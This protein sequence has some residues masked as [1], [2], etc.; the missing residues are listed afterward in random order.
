MKRKR[1]I[2]ISSLSLTL[3]RTSPPPV[4]LLKSTLTYHPIPHPF[5]KPD[6]LLQ[7]IF[8]DQA[9]YAAEA[10]KPFY[11]TKSQTGFSFTSAMEMYAENTLFYLFLLLVVCFNHPAP[12]TTSSSSPTKSIALGIC[13]LHC[14]MNFQRPRNFSD[15]V[16][17]TLISFNQIPD[18]Q[19]WQ[20]MSD[21]IIGYRKTGESGVRD[22]EVYLFSFF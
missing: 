17:M 8:Q 20:G 21:L 11:W 6:C 18:I 13:S 4:N 7:W 9:L 2:S 16:V 1:K 19:I 14:V 3:T 15:V 12:V 5:P 10:D 22:D